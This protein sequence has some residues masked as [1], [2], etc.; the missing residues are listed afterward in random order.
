MTAALAVC[1]TGKTD[2]E[3][4]ELLDAVTQDFHGEPTEKNPHDVQK[5]LDAP[6]ALLIGGDISGVQKFIYTLS[7]K[8]AAKTLRGRSFYLQ[9]LTE[10]VLRYVLRVLGLPATNVIYSGGGHFYLLAPLSAE[11]GVTRIQESITR[12]LLKYHGTALYLALGCAEV[13]ASGF[14][15]GNFP[16][17]WDMMHKQLA[18]AKVQRYAELGDDLYNMVFEPKPHGGNREKTCAV[19]GEERQTIYSLDGEDPAAKQC[20]FCRSFSDP[21]GRQLP[22][23][24][25][26]GIGLRE[27]RSDGGE[28]ALDVLRAFGLEIAWAGGA[29]DQIRFE[30]PVERSLTWALDDTEKWPEVPGTPNAKITRFTVNIIPQQM[31][32]DELQEKAKGIKRLGVLRMDVDDLGTIFKDGFGMLDGSRATLARLSTLS[33]Q[34]S[35]FFEGW[36]EVICARFPDLIYA[37]Y[38]GGDDVFLIG[39]WDIMPELAEMITADFSAYTGNNPDIHISGGLAFIHGKYPVYQAAQDAGDAERQAKR[40][41][42]KDAF[43]FLGQAWKWEEFSGIRSKKERITVIVA[44]EGEG[45]LGGPQALIQKLRQLALD[46]AA[47]RSAKGH[48][49]VYGRWMWQGAYYLKRM[50]EL[51]QKRRPGVAEKIKE[52]RLDLEQDNYV[53]ISQWGAAARWAQLTL[54]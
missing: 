32:F 26:V 10:A 20:S 5:L 16:R 14:R 38:A 52:I 7:S 44:P 21:I 12:V 24:K 4:Q 9:L 43:S 23:S 1:L 3:I 6:A 35:L 19:C 48:R 46:E 30:N 15:K 51:A 49:L 47:V 45:G 22:L 17:Y 42:G 39:P 13:P 11:D 40:M 27:P 53:S 25:F 34:M 37:V 2:G 41:G 18:I 33:F 31:R 36:I 54:R 8:G 50:E 28:T 29:G